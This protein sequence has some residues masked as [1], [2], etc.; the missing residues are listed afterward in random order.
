MQKSKPCAKVPKTKYSDKGVMETSG[1]L[2]ICGLNFSAAYVFLWHK[3][4]PTYLAL[5]NITVDVYTVECNFVVLMIFE[6]L[7]GSSNYS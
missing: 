7:S 1:R 3:F 5:F 4:P 2:N 6:I